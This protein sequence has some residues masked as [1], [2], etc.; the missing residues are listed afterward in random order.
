M[1]QPAQNADTS[2]P[3]AFTQGVGLVF[4][5]LGVVQFIVMMT[6]CCTSSLLS[7]DTATHSGL[8]QIGL[9]LGAT[10]IYTAQQAITLSVTCGV[11]FGMA[12]AGVGLGLQSQNR[13]TPAAAIALT[14]AASLFWIAHS[15]FFAIT[16][17]SILLTEG[18]V[19]LSL[20]FVVCF[21]FAIAA[22]KEM[23]RDPPPSGFETLP[24]DYKVPY[25][26][27]HQDPPD[28]RYAAESGSKFRGLPV[29]SSSSHQS[30]FG[31]T[32]ISPR[33]KSEAP[34][35]RRDG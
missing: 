6:I 27:M 31:C 33:P 2:P 23:R 21:G 9:R 11:F 3:R 20:M 24:P 16:M 8:D 14:L 5:W 22:A 19:V 18:C 26:H 28:V 17:R 30:A 1:D 12:M 34:W 4:Q 10:T 15:L 13:R 29:G 32:P 7:K 25:S 35:T